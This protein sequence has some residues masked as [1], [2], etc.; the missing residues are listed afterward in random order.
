MPQATRCGG[1][2]DGWDFG[3]W[4]VNFVQI[5]LGTNTTFIQ[6]LAGTWDEWTDT[7]DWLSKATS[8]T[9]PACFRGV[10]VEPVEDLV[11]QHQPQAAKLPWV[12][13]VQAAIGEVDQYGAN[14]NALSLKACDEFAAEMPLA[15]RE[16]FAWDLMCLRNMST[17]GCDHPELDGYN[18]YFVKT[19]GRAP[20]FRQSPVDVW[21]YG[22]LARS[23]NFAGC[24]VL[25][26]DA[27]GQD[28]QILRS[29]ITHCR[30]HPYEWPGLIQ[31][32]TMGHCDRLEG[33]SVEWA[34]IHSLEAHGY[35][36]VGYSYRDT[37]LAC[38]EAMEGS[39]RLRQ[40]V[41]SWVCD[42]CRRGQRFP[43]VST[44]SGI[45]CK[46]CIDDHN[47]SWER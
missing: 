20:S 1:L 3:G 2:R 38:K 27:E 13:L 43:Y 9:R 14:I 32:E 44:E 34:V 39:E 5:G 45:Y 19:Y 23:L 40:W 36:L 15:R 30:T 33:A 6:N 24:E 26:I 37:H 11:K 25:M 17:I 8:E 4:P 29:V 18:E 7:I 42:H 47:W 35:L 46:R 28:A 16:K 10:A 41:S 21:S 31:F 22:R 12:R